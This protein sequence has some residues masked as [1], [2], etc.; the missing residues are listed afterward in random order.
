M[1]ERR[2]A[3][4]A[5]LDSVLGSYSGVYFSRSRAAGLFFMAA[6]FT[7]PASG[8]AGLGSILAANGAA[9][10]MGFDREAIRSGR[11]GLNALLVG[12]GL[13]YLSPPAFASAPQLALAA[14]LTVVV[15]TALQTV[16]EGVFY[17]PSLSLG[18]VLA[19]LAVDLAA[20]NLP[21]LSAPG[22]LAETAAA[23]GSWPLP[24]GIE[25]YLQALGAVFFRTDVRSGLLVAAG[26]AAASRI[27]FVLS[28]VGYLAG[29]A[30]SASAGASPGDAGSALVAFNFILAAIALGGVY[31]VPSLASYLLATLAAVVA[32]VFAG[33]TR[34]VMEPYGIPVLS[35]PFIAATHLFILGL[36][37]RPAGLA[38]ELVRVPAAS[39]EENLALAQS[40]RLWRASG[41]LRLPFLGVWTVTQGTEGAHTHKER[42]RHALDFALTD[43]QGGEF[44]GDPSRLESYPAYGMPV[45]APGAGVVARVVDGVADNPPGQMD[46]ERNWGNYVSLRHIDGS[47][48]LLA[49]LKPGSIPVKTGDAVAPGAT[50]GRCG[51][52]GRSP[53]PHIHYHLQREPEPGGETLPFAFARFVVEDGG[54]PRLSERRLPR[55]GER[56]AH[57]LPSARRRAAFRPPIGSELSF[58]AESGGRRWREDLVAQADLDGAL[59]LRSTRDGS[60]LYYLDQED[61]FTVTHLVARPRTLLFAFFAAASRVPLVA[62]DRLRWNSELPVRPFLGGLTRAAADC[63]LPFL[64]GWRVRA[65][66]SFFAPPGRAGAGFFGVEARFIGM[67]P[68]RSR[69]RAARAV[70]HEEAGLMEASLI[71]AAGRAWLTARRQG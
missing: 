12:L 71:D 18:F 69:L 26:L 52:S 56:A 4:R 7:S 51:N 63:I 31:T 64:P 40:R 47:H 61:V 15:T 30:F 16:L 65:E 11:Y 44:Q 33:A 5:V 50:L 17:L 41:G 23:A 54:V 39:P 62:D 43:E 67:P 8:L 19:T 57:P 38:P 49:H 9:F 13:A 36:R 37:S 46:M 25:G 42:W 34:V 59:F 29:A 28:A 68:G 1:A 2:A 48:S 53:Q 60:R 14:V 66:Q 22:S 55:E 35:I 20:L 3:A 32:A 27:S 21:G 58:A 70:F 10:L 6:T 45:V 24:R